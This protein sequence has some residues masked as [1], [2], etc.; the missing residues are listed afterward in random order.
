MKKI[1]KKNQNFYISCSAKNNGKGKM[2]SFLRF[3][4]YYIYDIDG[5]YH[6]ETERLFQWIFN[7]VAYGEREESKRKE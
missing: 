4:Y 3:A 7:G 5:M 1:F 2:L 6:R